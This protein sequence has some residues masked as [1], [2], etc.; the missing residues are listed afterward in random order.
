[1]RCRGALLVRRALVALGVIAAGAAL[2]CEEEPPP[3]P[4]GPPPIASLETVDLCGDERDTTAFV[5]EKLV[6]GGADAVVS[7]FRQSVRLPANVRTCRRVQAEPVTHDRTVRIAVD[8]MTAQG[9]RIGSLLSLGDTLE[10]LP[11]GVRAE[12]ITV[13]PDDPTQPEAEGVRITISSLPD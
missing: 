8:R 6:E 2:G 3:P 5:R 4:P 11:L 1:M 10:R 7:W 13:Y 12:E 9:T